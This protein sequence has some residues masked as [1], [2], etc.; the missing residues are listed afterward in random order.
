MFLVIGF[1]SWVRTSD[2]E[3]RVILADTKCHFRFSRGAYQVRILSAMIS[4]VSPISLADYQ[5]DIPHLTLFRSGCFAKEITIKSRCKSFYHIMRC[6]TQFDV[7]LQCVSTLP[8]YDEGPKEEGGVQT[9]QG[10]PMQQKCY[11]AF[12]W[13]MVVLTIFFNPH[14]S[15]LV[16]LV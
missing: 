4:T 8:R 15:D 2:Q 5:D 14:Y 13:S 11:R 16:P 7:Q 9:V 6:L 3:R 10:N 12:R 1:I